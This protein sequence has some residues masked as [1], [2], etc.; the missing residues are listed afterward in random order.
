MG[1]QDVHHVPTLAIGHHSQTFNKSPPCT[2]SN[3]QNHQRRPETTRGQI[4]LSD[5]LFSARN[6]VKQST[7]KPI[8]QL[9]KSSYTIFDFSSPRI[10]IQHI[11]TSQQ[12][13]PTLN[14]Q[15]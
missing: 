6:H 1:Q 7:S 10:L 15:L 9:L 12:S 3:S 11:D 13:T 4:H 14:D 8:L 2:N 5:C